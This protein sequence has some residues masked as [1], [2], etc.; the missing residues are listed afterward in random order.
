MSLNPDQQQQQTEPTPPTNPEPKGEKMLTQEEVNAIVQG[1]VNKLK[2]KYKDYE[3]LQNKVAAFEAAQQAKADAELS[4]LEKAQKALEEKE[5]SL[6]E[7]Q[8]QIEAMKAEAKDQA[9][10]STFER[11]AR[12]ANIEY[13]E[14][15][16]NLADLSTVTYEDGKVE[17]VE[18]IIAALVESKPYL[19]A[20][21]QQKQIGGASNGPTHDSTVSDEDLLRAAAEKARKTGRLEDRVAYAHLKRQLASK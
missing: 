8:K 21:Q 20:K 9:I 14:D 16:F 19:L 3:D 4:E 7:L 5:G 1:K 6:S 10:H 17:G 12:K 13:I 15:A 18:D 11:V 2:E